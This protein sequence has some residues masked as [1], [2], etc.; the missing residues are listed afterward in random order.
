MSDYKRITMREFAGVTGD[1]I[2]NRLAEFEDKIENGEI[3]CVADKDAEISRLQAE[4]AELRE[5]LNR[6]VEVENKINNGELVGA[7]WFKSWLNG[8]VCCGRVVGYGDGGFVIESGNDLISAKKIYTSR[9]RAEK[10]ENKTD[11]DLPF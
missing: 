4:V 10:E 3:D 1:A 9:E 11:E 2:Y 5:R 8:I 7:I 6:A